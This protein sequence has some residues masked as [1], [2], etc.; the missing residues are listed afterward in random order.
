MSNTLIVSATQV[1]EYIY[2]PIQVQI[3]GDIQLYTALWDT[4]TVSRFISPHVVEDMG[5][6]PLEEPRRATSILGE[7]AYVPQYTVDLILPTT[8]LQVFLE[9]NGLQVSRGVQIPNIYEADGNIDVLVGMDVIG[10]GD[11]VLSHVGGKTEFRFRMP[12]QG[13]GWN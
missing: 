9:V 12:S 3:L 13:V 6:V 7:D 2:S 4:A 1:L 5:L 8:D 10:Q 11:L